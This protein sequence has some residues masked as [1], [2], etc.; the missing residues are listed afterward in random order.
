MSDPRD[1][2]EHMRSVSL[3]KS[4]AQ[5]MRDGQAEERGLSR[6]LKDKRGE[7]GVPKGKS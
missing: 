2:D 6:L 7:T 3:S 5:E 4:A 1:S